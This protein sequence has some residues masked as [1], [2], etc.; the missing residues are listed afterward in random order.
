MKM[1]QTQAERQV[2]RFLTDKLKAATSIDPE[3][4]LIDNR[5]ITSMG[6]MNFIL[7]LE[8]LTE[9]PISMEDMNVE[10]FRTL[11]RIRTKFLSVLPDEPD[12]QA[13]HNERAPNV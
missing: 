3:Q 2:V 8:E 11:R 5:M 6:F 13:S 12:I 9:T 1:T 7:L 10:D 4:D